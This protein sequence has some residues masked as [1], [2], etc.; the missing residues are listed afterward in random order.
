[1]RAL[2]PVFLCLLLSTLA[3]ADHERPMIDIGSGT[4]TA[5]RGAGVNVLLSAGFGY[6]IDGAHMN[7]VLA[8]IKTDV[9]VSTLEDGSRVPAL[10]I[11]FVPAALGVRIIGLRAFPTRITRDVRIDQEAAVRV[12]VVGFWYDSLPD[13]R[14][15]P[16]RDEN[17]LIPFVRVAVDALGYKMASHVSALSAFHGVSIGAIAAEGGIATRLSDAFTVRVSVGGSADVALGGSAG[18]SLQSDL[19]AYTQV[20]ADIRELVTLFVRGG[21]RTSADTGTEF[22][23]TSF[24]LLAGATFHF[25]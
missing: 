17:D 21:A 15:D 14:V 2:F 4:E 1:M 25:E 16:T 24:Q 12:N 10:D 5:S 19:N 9:A 22:G 6:R 13:G 8:R 11:E 7:L 20:A 3:R 23:Q 18:F